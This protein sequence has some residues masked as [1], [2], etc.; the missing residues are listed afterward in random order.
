MFEV[1]WCVMLYST[2][3][4][5]EF[6][7]LVFERL[8]WDRP[9][10]VIHRFTIPLVIAGVLLSTLH[11]SSLGTVFLVVPGKLYRLW[12]SPYLPVMFFLSALTVGFAMVMVESYLSSYF[13]KHSLKREIIVD[14][15]RF[16]SMAL[17]FY[18]AVKFQDLFARG[19][20]GALLEPRLETYCFWLEVVLLL[21]PALL[22]INARVRWNL[23]ASF[24][25]ALLVVLGVVVN[26]LNVSIV[27]MYA[28]SG[29]IYLPSWGELGISAFLITAGVLV[30]GLAVKHL[31]VFEDQHP[32][33]SA[34]PAA[35][36][37]G[38]TP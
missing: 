18:L 27:G 7:P 29:N 17:F 22:L 8:G 14:V 28:S 34:A 4:T 35:V 30:F 1:A 31:N 9:R 37:A 5:L 20:M 6:S 25:C 3:L 33:T 36:S 23:N 38:A 16:L 21:A 11:Q 26:R 10:R 13:L 15:S 19:H 32:E 12:Y 2:V 24:L